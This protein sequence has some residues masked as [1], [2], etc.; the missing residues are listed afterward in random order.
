MIVGEFFLHRAVEPFCMS[1]LLRSFWTSVIV[2]EVK[3]KECRTEM[4][5]ELRPLS[6]RTK[7]RGNGKTDLQ[8]A[9]KSAAA[10]EACEE[11]AKAKPK[12]V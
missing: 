6:V 2:S 9:K 3:L 12:R 5:L 11:V 8:R 1:V 7:V 4:L 10:R